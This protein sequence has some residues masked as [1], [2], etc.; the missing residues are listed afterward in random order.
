MFK[1]FLSFIFVLFVSN[2]IF[3]QGT[4]KGKVIDGITG[5]PLAFAKVKVE[6]LNAG[7]NSDFD[8][9]YTI[10][11]APGTYTLIFSL[12]TDGYINIKKEIVLSTEPLTLDVAL[13]KDKTMTVATMT[14][15]HVSLSL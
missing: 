4:V 7:A 5:E 13:L 1:S 11:I 10:K 6:G 15:T 9:N 2:L 12:S 8:G 14:V 3:G